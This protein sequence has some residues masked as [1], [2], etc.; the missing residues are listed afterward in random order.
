MTISIIQV[1][2]ISLYAFIAINESLISNSLNQPVFAGFAA[3]IIMG[4]VKTG[5]YVGGT[6]QLMRLGVAAFGG[7]TIPDY[8]SGAL[9][10]TVFGAIKGD[11]EFGIATAAIMATLA[12]NLD[13]L[14]RFANVFILHRIDKAI[15]RKEFKKVS[16]F[17][18]MGSLCWGL[19]RAIPIFIILSFGT[20]AVE[21]IETYIPQ[22]LMG[23]LQTAGKVLPVI[24]IAILLR[25]L[26]FKQYIPFMLGGFVLSAYLGMPMLGIAILGVSAALLIF[27][28][29]TEKTNVAT[30]TSEIPVLEGGFGGDE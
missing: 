14:G 29:D 4:D 21:A 10:G 27:K 13:I 15:D 23:G 19:S 22:W 7:A 16:P 8:L 28:K 20:K 17:V 1:L 12:M 11:A 26:P 3:G 30:A 2:L 24:G 6:L 18:L 25:Y 5:L 9:V